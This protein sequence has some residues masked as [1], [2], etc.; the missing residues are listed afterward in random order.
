MLNRIPQKNIIDSPF[1]YLFRQ[2]ATATKLLFSRQN[3]D[4]IKGIYL[5]P[6]NNEKLMSEKEKIKAYYAT[7]LINNG[8]D[9]DQEI[10]L[11]MR[12]W[13]SEQKENI[14][15]LSKTIKYISDN[16]LE[17]M[18]LN[19]KKVMSMLLA[20]SATSAPTPPFALLKLTAGAQCQMIGSR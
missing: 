11:W 5:I 3:K 19:I 16:N 10:S 7:D 9:F 14:N 2:F 12:Y 4:E 8:A 6:S 1:S 18:F 13:A 20:T 15:S 17:V